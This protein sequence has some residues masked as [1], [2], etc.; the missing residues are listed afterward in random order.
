MIKSILL[1]GVGGQG[2]L[3]AAGVIASA[4]EAAGFNV[5]TNEIHGMAQRGGSVTAQVRYGDGTFAPLAVSGSIDVIAA[6][7]HIEAI[8]WAHCL[9]P[10]GLAVVAKTSVVPVTVTTGACSYPEDVE[11]RLRAVFPRL[12][13]LDCA[14]LALELG[15]VRLANTILT[16]AL[17]AGLPEIAEDHWRAGLLARVKKGFEEANTTAFLKGRS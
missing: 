16:G 15:N 5:T 13:Y 2:I 3:F 4:A 6:M 7:E 11:Q 1:T 9:K 17:S 10:D 14:T 8:R 12:V